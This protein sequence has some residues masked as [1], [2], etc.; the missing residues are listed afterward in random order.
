MPSRIAYQA[1][2]PLARSFHV[3]CASWGIRETSRQPQCCRRLDAVALRGKS[4]VIGFHLR[5]FVVARTA[6]C[7]GR[8][9]VD[10]DI[11]SYATAVALM[12]GWANGTEHIEGKTAMAR[13]RHG[14]SQ[15]VVYGFRPQFAGQPR[16]TYKL[17][18]QRSPCRDGCRMTRE[19]GSVS[20]LR[21]RF[22][23]CRPKK[24]QFFIEIHL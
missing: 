9:A 19:S 3:C 6:G 7:G 14:A 11:V 12:S 18:F 16:G 5:C 20:A 8:I 24:C 17:I 15:V 21:T 2:L 13:G 22:I 4:T 23:Q 1:S 10:D